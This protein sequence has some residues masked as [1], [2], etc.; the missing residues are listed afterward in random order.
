MR[1]RGEGWIKR[2]DRQKV[3]LPA[4]I[5]RSDGCMRP[6]KVSNISFDGCQIESDET[7][8]IGELISI[9]LPGLGEIAAQIRW[10]LPGKAGACFLSD[11]AGA[12]KRRAQG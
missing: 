5:V 2:N 7:L 6:A 12:H 10:A 8:H 3:N 1:R 9:A 4:E 11:D